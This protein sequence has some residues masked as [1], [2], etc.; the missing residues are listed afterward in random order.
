MV[1][2]NEWIDCT[3]EN[4]WQTEH[5]VFYIPGDEKNGINYMFGCKQICP[6]GW[7]VLV[8]NN[9]KFMTVKLPIRPEDE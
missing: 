6:Y 8:R 5:D 9:A 4:Y 3:E 1:K 2:Y 7:N